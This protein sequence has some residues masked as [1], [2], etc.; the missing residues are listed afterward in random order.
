MTLIRTVFELTDRCNLNCKHC[1][2]DRHDKPSDL[3][4]S[5]LD[6][7]LRQG[8]EAY[9]IGLTAFTGGE[10]LMHKDFEGVVKT[11]VDNDYHFTFVTNGTLIPKR[12]HVLTD[13]EVKKRL[14]NVCVSLDGHTEEIH[15]S[16]RG[17][18]SFR[19]AMAAIMILKNAGIPVVIKYTIGRHNHDNIEGALLSFA[20]LQADRVEVAH[21]YPT[22]DNLEAGLMLDPEECRQVEATVYRLATELKMPVTMTAGVYSPQT[23]Y[24]C[25]S[26][27]MGDFYIDVKGRLCLCCM[28]PG[29]RGR[30][31]DEEERDIIADLN[32]VDL[33]TAHKKLL[34]LITGMQRDRLERIGNGDLSETDRF[35]CIAC[36]RYLGK[37]D[38]LSGYKDNPW[39][40]EKGK[41][42]DKG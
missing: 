19:K 9:G 37:L 10:P 5:L 12:I 15:D 17:E 26:I 33:W 2:R 42:E 4:L 18:G 41:E 16:I 7:V 28:L 1:M 8:K 14:G 21:T 24:S 11:V 6:K 22:P 20:H 38:W 27:D 30:N 32:E 3:S 31:A 36:A 29:I 39:S 35:Q 34:S 13:P 23:F 40:S 25:S